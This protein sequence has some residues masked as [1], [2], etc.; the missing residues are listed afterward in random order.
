MAAQTKRDATAPRLDRL[1]LKILAALQADGRMT[2]VRLAEKVGL[3][4]TPCL[5]R[6]RR[7]EKAGYIAGYGA[8]IDAARLGASIVVFTEITLRSH[9][10]DDFLRFERLVQ[11][12]P[13]IVG[14][15]LVSGGYDYLVQFM[16]RDVAHYQDIIEA[17]LDRS[18]SI[19]K[20]FSYIAI[21]H[22]KTRNGVPLE[23]FE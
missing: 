22:I 13:H 19:E 18:G 16:A 2:N 9:T 6:V 1:D 15:H 12:V 7:L 8:R 10:R 17:L 21:K 20:Y 4:P 14:C 23:L 11:D 5:Q 3:S